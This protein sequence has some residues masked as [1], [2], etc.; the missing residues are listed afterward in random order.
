M[1]D[2]ILSTCFVPSCGLR[3][4]NCLD[5]RTKPVDET[6]SDSSSHHMT[7]SQNY[8]FS[9]NY[10]PSLHCDIALAFPGVN[11]IGGT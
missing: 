10:K 4:C 5:S 3:L 7:A 8:P 11:P 9:V 6:L 1:I 2:I